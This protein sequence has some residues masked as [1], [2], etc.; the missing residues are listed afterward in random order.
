[1]GMY[2][3]K[4]KQVSIFVKQEISKI[5]DNDGGVAEVRKRFHCSLEAAQNLID[6]VEHEQQIE[7]ARR[8]ERELEL[9]RKAEAQKA[10]PKASKIHTGDYETDW[11]KTCGWRP[12]VGAPSCYR[13]TINGEK[14]PQ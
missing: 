1:M 8:A 10:K 11:C 4:R 5:L 9:Y 6:E 12:C 13:M 3:N 14:P 7:E 2:S